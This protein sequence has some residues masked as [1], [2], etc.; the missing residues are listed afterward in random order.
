MWTSTFQGAHKKH[1]L[2]T[3]RNRKTSFNKINSLPPHC[4]VTIKLPSPE[5]EFLLIHPPLSPLF[6][7]SLFC[8]FANFWKE[9]VIT[10]KKVTTWH[11][12]FQT[13]NI[14]K[15]E[16]LTR[17]TS[18]GSQTCWPTEDTEITCRGIQLWRSSGPGP[19]WLEWGLG[20]CI[21]QAPHML[22]IHKAWEETSW[23]GKGQAE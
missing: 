13:H 21:Q 10:K 18:N 22:L 16:F 17:T 4:V 8:Y 5:T 7:T 14:P 6:S 23:M 15:C 19:R 20:F 1:S 11:P 12:T 3:Q 9:K 2:R